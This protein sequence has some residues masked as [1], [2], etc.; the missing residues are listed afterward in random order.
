[1]GLYLTGLLLL[2]SM[3]EGDGN[4]VPPGLHLSGRGRMLVRVNDRWVFKDRSAPVGN[5]VTVSFARA[6]QQPGSS[7]SVPFRAWM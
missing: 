2:S 7:R 3:T 6:R 4:Q 5:F 1:M